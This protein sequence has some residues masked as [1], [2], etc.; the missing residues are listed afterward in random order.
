MLTKG[1]MHEKE[2]NLG[3]GVQG[4]WGARGDGPRRAKPHTKSCLMNNM[5][6]LHS[7]SSFDD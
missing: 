3:F 6:R 4:T 5:R 2:H 7:E 1:E